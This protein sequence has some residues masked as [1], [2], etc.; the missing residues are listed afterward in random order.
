MGEP[1]KFVNNAMIN[2]PAL[3]EKPEESLPKTPLI[4]D[5]PLNSFETYHWKV[6]TELTNWMGFSEED[7]MKKAKSWAAKKQGDMD[8]KAK[9]LNYVI[10]FES[11]HPNGSSNVAAI[12]FRGLFPRHL[13]EG[14]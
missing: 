5:E 14:S 12:A 8:Q 7:R 11:H 9:V 1:V 2:V 10:W 3:D 6:K 13:K 4:G